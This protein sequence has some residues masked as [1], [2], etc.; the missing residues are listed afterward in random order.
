MTLRKIEII[1]RFF[2]KT[3]NDEDLRT[4]FLLFNSK[5]GHDEINDILDTDW[6]LFECDDT[7]INM[8]SEKMFKNIKNGIRCNEIMEMKNCFIRRF[9]FAA[10]IVIVIGL[11]FF[12]TLNSKFS[13][14][15]DANQYTSVITEKGQR[16]KLI[17]PD[18]SIV[19]LNSDTKL[20]Y[21][22]SSKNKRTIILKGQGFFSVVHNKKRPFIV[23]CGDIKV[24]VLGTKFDVSAYPQYD[25]IS[26][27]LQSGKILLNNDRNTLDLKLISGE[28]A[29]YNV[30]EKKIN[31]HKEN[32][33]E[34]TSWKNGELRFKNDPM[35]LVIEK[36]ERWYNIEIEVKDPQVY[37]SVFTGAILNKSYEQIFKLI[38]Y[39]CPVNF[40]VVNNFN[41]KELP[42]IVLYSNNKKIKCL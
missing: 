21:N 40:D 17:L 33:K 37:K 42:K 26:V 14:Q 8:N 27:A 41:L 31:I 39:S 20:S 6:N 5:K 28:V 16:S 32:V 2:H 10:A 7:M 19:W 12:I 29:D 4:L 9:S 34:L 11:V 30:K 15:H 25:K 13:E 22:Y 3:C 18:S 35:K 23:Q 24:N 1:K 36:L 38:E